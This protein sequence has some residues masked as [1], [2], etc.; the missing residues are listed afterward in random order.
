MFIEDVA[1][2]ELAPMYV[3]L[4]NTENLVISQNFGRLL[5]QSVGKKKGTKE[6]EFLWGKKE[7]SHLL[8]NISK[9]DF[10]F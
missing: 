9:A 6:N 7:K 2:E 10:A 1:N 4:W 5:Y 8:E 3:D